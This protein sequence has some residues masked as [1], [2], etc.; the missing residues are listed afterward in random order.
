ML[1]WVPVISEALAERHSLKPRL[2]IKT[3]GFGLLDGLGQVVALATCLKLP[4]VLN[5]LLVLLDY[6]LYAFHIAFPR[7]GLWEIP[8]LATEEAVSSEFLNFPLNKPLP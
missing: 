3:L 6:V 2:N 5:H 4:G 7:L 1:A 8:A